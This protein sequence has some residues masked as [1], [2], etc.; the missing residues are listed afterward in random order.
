M[1]VDEKEQCQ[2]KVR[3]R[4]T[5]PKLKISQIAS[6]DR[7]IPIL[8]IAVILAVYG[9]VICQ[10]LADYSFRME[11]RR[12]YQ[13]EDVIVMSTND[14]YNWLKMAREL[15]AGSLGQGP[16]QAG[17][18]SAPAGKIAVDR[19]M[20]RLGREVGAIHL[21][22]RQAVKGGGNI[23]LAELQAFYQGFAQRDLGQDRGGGDGCGATEG[24]EADF[25]NN[26]LVNFQEKPHHVAAGRVAD[27]ADGISVREIPD[28]ARIGKMI[29]DLVSIHSRT[30]A[31]SD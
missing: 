24:L 13:V 5:E 28:I 29:H 4:R 11:N 20:Q 3:R 12:E 9:T 31:Y 7:T 8:L 21:V 27:L 30:F 14:A 17:F 25:G 6:S 2:E 26:A 23:F 16:E 1:L 15:D 22:V 18:D 10:R 19:L